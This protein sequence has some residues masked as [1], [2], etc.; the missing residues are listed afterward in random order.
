MPKRKNKS[1]AKS[2]VSDGKK[3][4]TTL[5]TCTNEEQVQQGTSNTTRPKRQRFRATSVRQ[6][7]LDSDHE[8][9]VDSDYTADDSESEYNY[10]IAF[11]LQHF[12]C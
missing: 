9:I 8:D 7:L 2:S 4:R 5:L 1:A 10:V 3:Q 12:G 11:S 6:M